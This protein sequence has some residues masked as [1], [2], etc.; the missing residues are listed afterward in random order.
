MDENNRQTLVI[1]FSITSRLKYLSHAET[2]RMF[3]RAL[4]RAGVNVCYS[5]GFNPHP[6]M[7]LPLPR[8]VGVASIGD[9]LSAS[10]AVDEDLDSE[11]LINNIKPQL[12]VDC[13]IDKVE[14]LDGKV[15]FK[16]AS[17]EFEF[18]VDKLNEKTDIR[19][20]VRKFQD[21]CSSGQ[22]LIL[23]RWS[24]K[25]NKQRQIDATNY[26]ETVKIDG[27]KVSVQIN[28]TQQGSIRVE[29]VLE[30][31]GVKINDIPS[32]VTRRNTVFKN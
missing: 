30:L 5:Q 9:L 26:I 21:M 24:R 7:S 22:Q 23:K 14:V 3:E 8:T 2:A 32:G 4:L 15:S 25:K 19:Q 31:A 27:N 10:V 17:T 11:Q 20:S 18:V 12:P 28:I 16:P 29:E 1:T 6:K 13:S